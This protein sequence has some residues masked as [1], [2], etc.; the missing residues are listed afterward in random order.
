MPQPLLAAVAVR[1]APLRPRA[2]VRRLAAVGGFVG[3]I[4]V[5]AHMKFFLPGNPIPLTLQTFFVLLAGAVLGPV[6]AAAA[7]AL[8]LGAGAAGVPLFA[9]ASGA[10]GFAYLGGVTGGYLAG[11]LPS[12]ILVGTACRRTRDLRKLAFV[13]PLAAMLILVT[14]G[15]HLWLVMGR[16]AS[17]AVRLG[18]LPFIPGD[19]FKAFLALVLYGLLL[20]P[21]GRPRM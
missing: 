12:A 4:A 1:R 15:L 7:V 16:D 2:L 21:I 18:V 3:L 8:Y 17:A 5:G 11:F 20:R 6:D 13:F 10:L 9:G 19:L 14:G